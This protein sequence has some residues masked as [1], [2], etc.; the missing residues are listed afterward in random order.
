[1]PLELS[2]NPESAFT[3]WKIASVAGG[4]EDE[5]LCTIQNLHWGS[6]LNVSRDSK[7]NGSLVSTWDEPRTLGS[8]WVVRTISNTCFAI[9][10]QCSGKFLT[11]GSADE[12]SM[13]KPLCQWEGCEQSASWWRLL[14]VDSTAEVPADSAAQALT[15]STARAPAEPV[16]LPVQPVA[17]DMLPTAWS[18]DAIQRP[19]ARHCN[20]RA[21]AAQSVASEEGA[22]AH[23]PARLLCDLVQ[24]GEEG[25][26]ESGLQGSDRK[27]V[28]RII[29][30]S[31]Q[32]LMH[33]A[34]AT[35]RPRTSHRAIALAS[36]LKALSRASKL[37]LILSMQESACGESPQ[38]SN[39]ALAMLQEG[40]TTRSHSRVEANQQTRECCVASVPQERLA[41]SNK[42]RVTLEEKE[43][44]TSLASELQALHESIQS[45]EAGQAS[46]RFVWDAIERVEASQPRCCECREDLAPQVV[47]PLQELKQA[48]SDYGSWDEALSAVKQMLQLRLFPS[49]ERTCTMPIAHLVYTHDSARS[50][51]CH[52]AHRGR[53][54]SSVIQDL[55]SG[56][57]RT[58]SD[59]M[60][61]DV[62][63]FHGK[64]WSLNNRHLKA[65]RGLLRQVQ[66]VSLRQEV[67]ARVR[68]WPLTT[69]VC[70]PYERRV[71]VVGKF[72][73]ALSTR[74]LGRS[75]S[76]KSRSGSASSLQNSPF[77]RKDRAVRF[78]RA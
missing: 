75:L 1:M 48:W 65:L 78:V 24:C 22:L 59:E 33:L 7:D 64:Y 23:K 71:D 15:D 76:L 54:V 14:V 70:L 28:V 38:C 16:A 21:C 9:R 3:H 50:S 30:N 52:G 12:A 66:P 67:I 53:S 39:G 68:V 49:T 60:I 34:R 37:A 35:S 63:Y 58:T 55:C 26:E 72:S 51:F 2:D 19:D 18:A 25:I 17:L 41:M 45:A 44:W 47:T 29:R 73:S 57:L 40:A 5:G 4:A 42:V 32:S 74:D 8:L 62:V 6:F 27:E 20:A 31:E 61:L 36:N 11:L 13:A 43:D 46:W 56:R 77:G 10:A 69:G